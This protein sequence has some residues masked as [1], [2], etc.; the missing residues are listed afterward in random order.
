[1]EKQQ[2]IM[3]A[4]FNAYLLFMNIDIPLDATVT[5]SVVYF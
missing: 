3:S 1:M 2:Q 4:Q 5:Y